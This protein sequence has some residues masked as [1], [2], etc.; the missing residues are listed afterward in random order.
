MRK[1]LI[2]LLCAALLC[3]ALPVVSAE[4]GGHFILTALTAGQTLIAP[5][6]I[7]YEAG[8]TLRQTRFC[9]PRR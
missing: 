6:A 8:Q 7:E 4:G 1:F 2:F 5:C 3:S 9:P